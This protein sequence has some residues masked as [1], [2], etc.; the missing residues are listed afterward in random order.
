MKVALVKQC[1]EPKRMHSFLR[2]ESEKGHI[3]IVYLNH[4]S[5]LEKRM[6]EDQSQIDESFGGLFTQ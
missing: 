3:S 5:T 6:E 4:L 2:E 1:F